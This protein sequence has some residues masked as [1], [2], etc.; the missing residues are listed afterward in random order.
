[1]FNA[2]VHQKKG[3]KGED[4]PIHGKNYPA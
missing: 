4:E 2:K 1:M 3:K